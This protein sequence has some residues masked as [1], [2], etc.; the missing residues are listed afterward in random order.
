MM[1][2]MVFPGKI[3]A[4]DPVESN[5]IG[6]LLQTIPGKLSSYLGRAVL[7][8]Y[9]GPRWDQ[10]IGTKQVNGGGNPNVWGADDKI[11]A[12]ASADLDNDGNEEVYVGGDFEILDVQTGGSIYN[13]A[14]WNGVFWERIDLNGDLSSDT[15]YALEVDTV[16][17]IVYFG[18]ND[19]VNPFGNYDGSLLTELS[20]VFGNAFP[21]QS[22][23]AVYSL[24][25]DEPTEI[26]YVGGRFDTIDSIV[27]YNLSMFDTNSSSF[28]PVPDSIGPGM[29]VNPYGSVG[30]GNDDGYDE[31]EEAPAYVFA[32]NK[33]EGDIYLGGIFRY[34]INL[35]YWHGYIAVIEGD[36]KL[37]RVFDGLAWGNS[38]EQEAVVRALEVYDDVLYIGGRFEYA[39]HS[40]S[41]FI[42]VDHIVNYK[43]GVPQWFD[44][45][46]GVQPLTP[47]TGP[48]SD[49]VMNEMPV[50][51]FEVYDMG[52]WGGIGSVIVIGGHYYKPSINCY[53]LAYYSTSYNW[54][55][56]LG[57]IK[58][59]DLEGYF[60]RALKNIPDHTGDYDDLFVGGSFQDGVFP[61]PFDDFYVNVY[62][63]IKVFCIVRLAVDDYFVAS[64][65]TMKNW[66]D[67]VDVLLKFDPGKL[68][69]TA[70][71]PGPVYAITGG[72]TGYYPG[73]PVA[74]FPRVVP[75]VVAGDPVFPIIWQLPA[76]FVDFVGFLQTSTGRG[77]ATVDFTVQRVGYTG[78]F[79]MV[80]LGQTDPN[81]FMWYP[82]VTNTLNIDIIPY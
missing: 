56:V 45:T 61:D 27:M 64:K 66:Q 57:G 16:Q 60:V 75:L 36:G 74:N 71:Y 17:N 80:G 54:G 73:I 81:N 62:D 49:D 65:D 76:I 51:A 31:P 28:S 10:W 40:Q 77:V 22:D 52:P 8:T 68:T 82:E 7:P 12:I 1:L 24:Y 33:Y 72:V 79:Y 39:H 18:S 4:A 78:P 32:I 58:D 42:D 69:K 30:V 63:P 2:L 29:E 13:I 37:H 46:K 44:L 9:D 70:G 6:N 50:Q 55:W 43:N 67:S 47:P 20:Y 11:Y 53:D 3:S 34:D 23:T 41:S 25:F 5:P 59:G 35:N 15:V 19:P 21:W 48:I 38:H 26:L 14:K